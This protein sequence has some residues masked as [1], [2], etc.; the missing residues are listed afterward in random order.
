[1]ADKIYESESIKG[2]QLFA[3]YVAIVVRNAMEGFHQKHLSDQQM[4]ELNPII[5]NAVY[6]AIYTREASD[7]SDKARVFV[8][9]HLAS[10][11]DYWEEPEFLEGFKKTM[12]TE[13]GKDWNKH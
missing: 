9:Y 13:I 2:M 12:R 5:R 10:I 7:K 6:T 3:K 11:P 8:K 1:M 4:K